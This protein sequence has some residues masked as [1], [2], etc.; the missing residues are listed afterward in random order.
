MHLLPDVDVL[1]RTQRQGLQSGRRRHEHRQGQVLGRVHGDHVQR[2]ARCVLR[3]RAITRGFQHREASALA[4]DDVNVGQHQALVVEHR[5]R[6]DA[7]HRLVAILRDADHQHDR[8]RRPGIHRD[9]ARALR[10]TTTGEGG[11]GDLVGR[12]VRNVGRRGDGGRDGCSQADESADCGHGSSCR[13]RDR[14]RRAGRWS[15]TADPVG[16][17][18]QRPACAMAL[19]RKPGVTDG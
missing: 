5:A 15:G 13:T 4:L 11:R 17:A 18:G 8:A 3:D 1:H 9:A 2:I 16:S 6:T 12:D 19:C 14:V 10:H 7:L